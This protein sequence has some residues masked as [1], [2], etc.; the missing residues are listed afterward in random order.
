M[1][2]P[3]REAARFQCDRSGGPMVGGDWDEAGKVGQGLALP[4]GRRS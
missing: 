1:D 4:S 2:H 3:E